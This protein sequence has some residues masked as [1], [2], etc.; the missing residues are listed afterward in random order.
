MV[1]LLEPQIFSI[2]SLRALRDALDVYCFKNIFSP[3]DIRLK[4]RVL[5][6]QLYQAQEYDPFHCRR[7][8]WQLVLLCWEARWNA[9]W[10]HKGRGQESSYILFWQYQ[11]RITGRGYHQHGAPG[12]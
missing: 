11:L 10:C 2:D 5:T 6:S 9:K 12:M 3:F 7:D 4:E 1:R 8:L